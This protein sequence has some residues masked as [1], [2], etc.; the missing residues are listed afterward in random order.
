VEVSVKRKVWFSPLLLWVAL[1]PAFLQQPIT[2]A[3]GNADLASLEL[4]VDGGPNLIVDFDSAVRSYDV[5]TSGSRVTVR[6]DALINSST[7]NWVWRVGGEVIGGDAIGVDGGEVTL[8]I[9][10]PDG[11][12]ELGIAVRAGA[13]TGTASALYNI[14]ITN[15]SNAVTKSIPMYCYTYQ[16]L[17]FGLVDGEF[18]LTVDPL[19][20][21]IAGSS[22]DAEISGVA[23]V[24]DKWPVILNAADWLTTRFAVGQGNISVVPRSGATGSAVP[25]E[26]STPTTCA[27]DA[28][29]NRGLGAGPF[30]SCDPAN[31]TGPPG[32]EFSPEPG[33]FGNT[34]CVGLGGSPSQENPCLPFRDLTIID[35]TADACAACN[36]LGLGGTCANFGVCSDSDLDDIAIPLAPQSVTLVAE[37][38][39]TEALFG[40][41]ESSVFPPPTPAF[42]GSHL[43]MWWE[44]ADPI[45]GDLHRGAPWEC[46][47][48]QSAS[49]ASYTPAPDSALLSIPVEPCPFICGDGTQ[50]SCE[51]C[52]DG[53]NV[54][55]DGC[56]AD[57]TFDNCVTDP[58]DC[59]ATGE[60]L[61]DGVCDPLCE[62]GTG[63]DRCPGQDLLIA[64]G[65]ACSAGSG[66][67][68]SGVCEPNPPTASIEWLGP[69]G[70]G[71]HVGW[72]TSCALSQDGSVAVYSAGGYYAFQNGWKRYREGIGVD[73]FTGL[74]FGMSNMDIT[75]DGTTV[76]GIGGNPQQAFRWDATTGYVPTALVQDYAI[77][78]DGNWTAGSV[79][80]GWAA[81][82]PSGLFALPAGP[83]AGY[84]RAISGNGQVVVGSDQGLAVPDAGPAIWTFDS[85][86]QQFILTTPGLGGLPCASKPLGVDVSYD[87]SVVVGGSRTCM[88]FRWTAIGGMQDLGSVTG[89]TE[90]GFATGISDDGTRIV[91]TIEDCENCTGG[92]FLWEAPSTIRF[93]VDVL[94]DDYG[95]T[96]PPGVT[97]HWLGAI[98]GDGQKIMGNGRGPNGDGGQVFLVTLGT[99]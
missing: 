65:T 54:D 93:L 9:F 31:N 58:V 44:Y 94:A 30:P 40:F 55:G 59:A 87:G 66:T 84:L 56:Q 10:L 38:G 19:D 25:L 8:P 95:L 62:P 16:L 42:D 73:D 60:C 92:P 79:Q 49:G 77:S 4:E 91:G 88:P 57:C 43:R 99:P 98:S 86:M 17:A 21:A 39:A 23:N 20:A 32:L 6:A 18:E 5:S 15:L 67:C 90:H 36:A 24:L 80:G 70:C 69:G 81:V 89:G 68:Q 61:T 14:N 27:V 47:M 35:G 2:C 78:P 75:A 96:L 28:N 22:F 72:N 37:P 82:G 11:Q 85:L 13:G 52:D 74:S 46:F 26:V 1:S 83:Y 53:N 51:Q 63:C 41:A 97:L 3:R 34:D 45:D 7:V 76:V 29:G 64:D 33:F 48:G 50:D 71:H 12:S